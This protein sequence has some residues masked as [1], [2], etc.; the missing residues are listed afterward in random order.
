MTYEDFFNKV[1]EQYGDAGA[2]GVLSADIPIAVLNQGYE[3]AL[4]I[5]LPH[6][7]EEMLARGE[8]E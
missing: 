4:A 3:A 6:I 7:E 8:I 2:E 5:A 1:V